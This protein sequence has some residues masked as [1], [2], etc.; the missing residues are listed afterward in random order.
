MQKW[1]RI[2][3]KEMDRIESLILFLDMMDM[4]F[5]NFKM[6]E[7]NYRYQFEEISPTRFAVKVNEYQKSKGY[8]DDTMVTLDNL[9]WFPFSELKND[10]RRWLSER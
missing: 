5:S 2:G 4:K 6:K 1:W 10:E 3:I 9:V 7:N 8:V